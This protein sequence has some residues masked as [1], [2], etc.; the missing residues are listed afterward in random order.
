MEKKR[1]QGNWILKSRFF[2]NANWW[3]TWRGNKNNNIGHE[4]DDKKRLIGLSP[5]GGRPSSFDEDADG[6]VA[7]NG[8][9]KLKN[10]RRANFAYTP[11][12]NL[13]SQH[14]KYIFNN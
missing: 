5:G 9:K 13:V 8:G 14:S 2:Q 3:C 4:E 7:A 6:F 12:K 11:K 1:A 10:F